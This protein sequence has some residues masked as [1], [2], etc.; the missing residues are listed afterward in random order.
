MRA[1]NWRQS[2]Q[3]PVVQA[4]GDGCPFFPNAKNQ[5][6]LD[7]GGLRRDAG[8]AADGG[9][10]PACEYTSSERRPSRGKGSPFLWRNRGNS[11]QLPSE[12]PPGLTGI[13]VASDKETWPTTVRF[14]T[15]FTCTVLN[16]VTT[17][18]VD[19]NTS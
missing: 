2:H 14:N 12:N 1:C 8:L 7:V 17:L 16:Q 9:R 15:R 6:A 18:C 13:N 10:A 19:F 3:E 11:F 5:C 4:L